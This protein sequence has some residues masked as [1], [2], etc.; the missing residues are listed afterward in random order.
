[1]Q[2][3]NPRPDDKKIRASF[4]SV[5]AGMQGREP[6]QALLCNYCGARVEFPGLT[7]EDEI[8]DQIG[9]IDHRRPVFQ[10]GDDIELNLQ[11]FCQTC[12][13][14]KNSVCRR[15]PYGHRCDS[16]IL[17]F[18]EAVRSQRVV[19]I[20]DRTTVEGLALK[21]GKD[22]EAKLSEAIKAISSSPK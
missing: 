13:N 16:C 9:L 20:L 11:I 4:L 1:M 6:R 7:A 2:D 17:A 19:L 10:G 3:P 21:F 22:V 14:K 12:N 15:C 8:A 18:P 5:L